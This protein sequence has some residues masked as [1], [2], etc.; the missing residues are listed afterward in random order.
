MLKDTVEDTTDNGIEQGV[1]KNKH[2]HSC[3]RPAQTRPRINIARGWGFFIPKLISK[4]INSRAQF[5]PI[6]LSTGFKLAECAIIF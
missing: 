6:K 2:N 3:Y 1:G 5:D 4:F